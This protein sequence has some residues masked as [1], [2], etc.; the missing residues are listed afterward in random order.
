MHGSLALILFP[1]NDTS[2][3]YPD[4]YFLITLLSLHPN[5]LICP[6]F[7]T[8]SSMRHIHKYSFIK[9]YLNIGFVYIY[10]IFTRYIFTDT[11]INP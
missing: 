2:L 9:T 7:L 5:L 8:V 11:M 10:I 4:E 1:N 6:C 3:G